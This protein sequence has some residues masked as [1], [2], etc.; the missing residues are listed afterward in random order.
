MKAVAKPTMPQVIIIRAIQRR[1]PNFSIATLLGISNRT[2][3]TKNSVAPKPNMLAVRPMSSFMVRAA[4]PTFT[5][6]M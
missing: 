6:S 5:R 1:A 2:Y 4:K 3:A